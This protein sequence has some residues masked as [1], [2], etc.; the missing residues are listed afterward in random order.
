[1][2]KQIVSLIVLVFFAIAGFGQN[3]TGINSNTQKPIQYTLIS[4]TDES[5]VIQFKVD[6]FNRSNVETP[7]G[8]AALISVPEMVSM[9]ETG[10]PDLPIYAVSTIIGNDASM[11]VRILS[12]E[13]TDFQGIEIAPSKGNFS[14]QINPDDI[15]YTYGEIY[16]HDAFY[17]ANLSILQTPYILRDLR[18]QAVTVQPFSYNPIQKI[19][20]VFHTFTIELFKNG[21]GGENQL[22]TGRTQLTVDPEFNQL[23]AHH[24]INYG[25][26]Q[27][28]YPTVEEEGNM[29]VI[30]HGPYME[31]M[32]P[33]IAWKKQIGRPIEIIDVA[34]IGS[35][36]AIIKAFVTDYYNNNGLTYLLLVGD[37]Q[38]VPSYNN[39]SSGGYSDN[40]Y[41]YL[42][43]SDS[44][45]E[46]FVGRFSAETV[47]HVETQV[48]KIITYERDMA[49][50]VD[51]VDV[52]MGVSRNEGAGNGHNGGEADYQHIDFIR[53]SLLN[54]TY[55]TV[56]REYDGNV[57]GLPN[58]TAAM[59]SQ[60][61]NDGVSIINYC[62]HGSQNS[63]S[64]G[65]YS[66]SHVDALTNTDR[67]PIVWAVACD[68]GRF[69]NGTCFAET[70]MRATDNGEPTGAIGT[71]MSWISQPWQPPM[72]GQDEMNTLLVEGYENNIKRTFGGCSINGSM[73]MIDEFGSEGRS[74]HDTWILFGDPSLCLRTANPT[75]MTVSHQPTIFL[76]MNQFVVNAD[77]ENAIVSLTY[78]GEILGTA[79]IQNGTATITFPALTEIGMMDVT[80]FAFNRV[81]YMAEV[82]ILPAAGPFIAYVSNTVNDATGNNNGMIDYG[83]NILLGMEIQNMGVTPATNVNIVLSCESSF[84]NITDG[85]EDFGTLIPEQTVTLADAFAFDVASDIPNNTT[86]TFNLIITSTES[87][88]ESSFNVNVLAPEFAVG[89]FTVSD[90][91]G[92]G[93]GRLDPGE[94][95]DITISF[96]NTGLS[97]ATD[98]IAVLELVNSYITVNTASIQYDNIPAGENINAGFNVTV[99][100]AA[101]IGTT[102]D[103]SFNVVAGTYQADKSFATKIGLILE[104][105]ETGDFNAF[106]WTSGGESAWKIEIDE[107]F[108]GDF[109]SRS[110]II[111]DDQSS[112]MLLTYAVSADDTISFYRKVSS[113]SGY[114]YLRFY[115]DGIEKDEW[116]GEQ[117]WSKVSYPVSAGSRTFKWEYQKDVSD[118][119]GADAAYIDY[120]VFP[121]SFVPSGYAGDDGQVCVGQTYPLN[122]VAYHY[123]TVLWSSSGDGT[124]SDATILNPVYT[125]G[126]NDIEAGSAILTLSV[127]GDNAT[128][129]SSLNL[130][131]QPTPVVMAGDDASICKGTTFEISEATAFDYV[132]LQWL[133]NG[134][135]A[136]DDVSLLNPV[137]MP[138]ESDFEAGSVILTLDATGSGNCGDATDS[139]VLNF[140]IIPTVTISGDQTICLGQNATIH[141]ELTGQ[142]PWTVEMNN[143]GM[144]VSANPFDYLIIPSV[145]TTYSLVSVSDANGCQQAA[146]GQVSITV[147]SA[148]AAP[149]TPVTPDTVD[150]VYATT[151]N[152]LIETVADA[153]GYYCEVTPTEAAQV[154]VSGNE[155]TINWVTTYLGNAT[156]KVASFNECGQSAWTDEK[157]VV[158]RNTVGLNENL[159]GTVNIFPNPGSGKFTIQMGNTNT[160]YRLTITNLPGEILFTKTL[161]NVVDNQNHVVDVSFLKNGAY[162]LLIENG[163]N[164]TV[165][166]LLINK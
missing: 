17:P 118:F 65:N 35:T 131:I 165:K 117:D 10:A 162:L 73:K 26:H 84:V 55:T 61:I 38:H 39:T 28:R 53:D 77:A 30:C 90:P 41:A 60:R 153:D 91:S 161:Y 18:G 7:R 3:W 8:K 106:D 164:K 48:E 6:G 57:P 110:G 133:T 93:N 103:F 20:R 147:I 67:W 166:S 54:F 115:I 119:G 15:P 146:N 127:T 94:T 148:P 19:L 13:Y 95:A 111:G 89:S 130:I 1:M 43:G 86:L 99:N 68:N 114:D 112:E 66:T 71:M 29:L 109:A 123:N 63:W 76:E 151:T 108:E 104:D 37:H 69:T 129:E 105:F 140:N 23:Y 80:V 101:P 92:N 122:G 64:V 74:T 81:T 102:V 9:L 142:A 34:T 100:P 75:P 144:V 22:T 113:E 96:S 137:Y 132:S 5:I 139:F 98:A 31:A 138:S 143:G 116:S 44:F 125:P 134:S 136:F 155:A 72:T 58:T 135:G 88:W 24:F 121:V 49:P 16:N 27:Q 154:T 59:I 47:T 150:Y 163:Y 21:T 62:N 87:S 42:E 46:L 126:S 124:F 52:G 82:E 56:H 107:T 4:S 149:V 158:L 25:V 157:P 141:F 45:N 14:R 51:W 83:E 40:Y 2:K 128:V 11:E 50:T 79:Y 78:N 97:A 156:I 160:I 159:I 70:W 120:I 145:S 152:V 85:S 33:F 12:S 36:P 32:A